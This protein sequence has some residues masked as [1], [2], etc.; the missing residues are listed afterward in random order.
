LFSS[1]EA[2]TTFRLGIGGVPNFDQT[3]VT[4][5][6]VVFAS[7]DENKVDGYGRQL[8]RATSIPHESSQAAPG[9]FW[10]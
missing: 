2:N 8:E 4:S 10:R 3:A 6:N 9:N 1:P 5:L 7:G